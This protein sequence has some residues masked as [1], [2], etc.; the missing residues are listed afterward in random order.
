MTVY[1]PFGWWLLPLAITV[2]AFIWQWWILKDKTTGGDYGPIGLAV[3]QAIT[4]LGA[5]VVSLF[6][7]LVWAVLT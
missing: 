5:L 3:F 6:A 1:I 2:A 4:F 7:W